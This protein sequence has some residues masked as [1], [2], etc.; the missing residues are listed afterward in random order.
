MSPGERERALAGAAV[1]A[2]AALGLGEGSESPNVELHGLYWLAANLAGQRPLL[3][4]V[5]DLHWGD[6]P[7]LRWLHY[8]AGRLDGLRALVVVATRP[9][10]RPLVAA[11][12][13][14]SGA[15]A[16]HPAGLSEAAVTGLVADRLGG[17]AAPGLRGG[18]SRRHPGQPI[19]DRRAAHRA[20]R[21]WRRPDPGRGGR[22]A[23]R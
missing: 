20:R 3:L 4:L 22:A 7:S 16:L 17:D 14:D 13:A 8:V 15:R 9:S 23:R 19:P 11:L 1:H 2:Q 6:E 10:D 21:R 12:L 5:D 18:L